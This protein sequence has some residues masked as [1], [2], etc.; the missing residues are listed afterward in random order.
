MP[1]A[2]RHDRPS[3]S[4]PSD[5]AV[6]MLD[7]RG[8]IVAIHAG[9]A[10]FGAMQTQDLIGKH[11]TSLYAG[12][13]GNDLLDAAINADG[14]YQF[15]CQETW[16]A[17]AHG[18]RRR[19]EISMHALKGENQ[20]LHGFAMVVRHMLP[21]TLLQDRLRGCERRFRLFTQC[22]DDAAFCMLDPQ[23]TVMDWNAGAQHLI[24]HAARSIVGK[25][26]ATFFSEP[27]RTG[28]FPV[29]LIQTASRDGRAC[30]G[31]ELL[32]AGEG[33][34]AEVILE[35][36][37][38]GDGTLLGFALIMRDRTQSQLAERR[39]REA[40]EQ[41]VHAQ[42]IEA[43]SH[44][45]GGIAHDFNNALQGIISS[46]ELASLSLDRHH[47]EQARR[48]VLLSLDAA[49]RAGRLTQRLL[50]LARRQAC[51]S[52]RTNIAKVFNAMRE[53]LGR[54]LGDGIMLEVSFPD[55]LP[56][57]ICDSGQLESALVNLA[58]NARDA[59]AG[60]GH[61][62]ISCRL[63]H[64]GDSSVQVSLDHSHDVYVEIC[65]TDDGPGMCSETRRRAFEPFFTT[66]V[67]GRGTGLGLSM[68]HGFTAQHGGAVDIQSVPGAGTSVLLYLPCDSAGMDIAPPQQ[69][70][71][72]PN[73]RGYRILV[74]EDNQ[75]IRESV[76]TRLRQ[77]GCIV[78][79]AATGDEA[80][81]MLA[82]NASWDL[83]LSDLDL[84][85]VDGYELCCQARKLLPKLRVILMTGYAESEWHDFKAFDNAMDAL[86]KPFDMGELLNKVQ[87][88][89][90]PAE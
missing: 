16:L 45:T 83:L 9:E 4:L 13:H 14:T 55:N 32:R 53:L 75:T 33:F 50:S 84:P 88:L 1:L 39:L 54:T 66:K 3:H 34:P 11:Y 35:A 40:R 57:L 29:H 10:S 90:Q 5:C 68:V 44:L 76:A 31:C 65:V 27:Q 82:G 49:L 73:L 74:V 43:M 52:Q 67:E 42:K 20:Q 81:S 78:A 19:V 69:P 2:L 7:R 26:F 22:V 72:A 23:G 24:G 46:L 77:L 63:C 64:P 17:Q 58:V 71:K 60:H 48:H 59:M 61:L 36:I 21:H 86:I 85:S 15:A 37:H 62:A 51:S 41:I 47:A 18:Q 56:P 87:V 30:V 38:D 79:E 80:L 89:L 70:K 25:S 8:C 28:E 6:F 12:S